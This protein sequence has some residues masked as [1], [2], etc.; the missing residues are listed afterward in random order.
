MR[1]ASI[2]RYNKCLDAIVKDQEGGA[3]SSKPINKNSQFYPAFWDMAGHQTKGFDR[4]IIPFIEA[5]TSSVAGGSIV[6]AKSTVS[7]NIKAAVTH[8]NPVEPDKGNFVC[9]GK[10]RELYVGTMGLD[11]TASLNTE[12]T[13]EDTLLGFKGKAKSRC[14][15]LRARTTLSRSKIHTRGNVWSLTVG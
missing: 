8:G 1:H 3:V 13:E 9:Y 11:L 7:S 12:D 15:S 6:P 14:C 2:I 10:Y 4:Y 5:A